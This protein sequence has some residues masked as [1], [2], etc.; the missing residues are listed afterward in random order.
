MTLQDF[1]LIPENY[2]KKDPR[3]WLYLYPNTVNIVTYAK[4]MQDFSFY[5]A[6]EVTEDFAKRMGYILVPWGCIHWQRQ[7]ALGNERKIKIGRKSFYYLKPSELTK[8]EREKLQKYLEEFKN[9]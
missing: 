2:K 6:L 4:K 1:T 3:A 9:S 5:Q 7:T 8:V